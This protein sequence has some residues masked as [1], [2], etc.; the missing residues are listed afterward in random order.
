MNRFIIVS[1]WV[2]VSLSWCVTDW[3]TP[4]GTQ[5]ITEHYIYTF[6]S[7]FSS[8]WVVD[9]LTWK[10]LNSSTKELVWTVWTIGLVQV[11]CMLV[12]END[13]LPQFIG[14]EEAFVARRD[15]TNL[16]HVSITKMFCLFSHTDTDTCYTCLFVFFAYCHQLSV[17]SSSSGAP[18]MTRMLLQ[19]EPKVLTESWLPLLKSS[20][21]KVTSPTWKQHE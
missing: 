1:G 18:T 4:Q 10:L 5:N 6:H 13:R 16:Y 3:L 15:T 8:S 2:W 20:R 17:A 19:M 14:I 21:W 11:Q 12:T 9:W 7:L